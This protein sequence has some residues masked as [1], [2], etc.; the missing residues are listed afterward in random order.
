MSK[1][2]FQLIK[3]LSSAEKRYFKVQSNSGNNEKNYFRLYVAIDKMEVYSDQ[4]LLE[5]FKHEAFIDNLPF[6]KNY[7]YQ[8]ILS[9]LRQ[10]YEKNSADIQLHNQLIDVLVLE[11]KGLYLQAIK[12]SKQLKKKANLH[13]HRLIVLEVIRRELEFA[14]RSEKNLKVQLEELGTELLSSLQMLETELRLHCLKNT[15]FSLQ[16]TKAKHQ[17]EAKLNEI[18]S[19]PLLH[20]KM[21]HLSFKGQLLLNWTNAACYHLKGDFE[22]AY[23]YYKQV[24]LLWQE[25]PKIRKDKPHLYKIHL[26]NFL[27]ICHDSSN[28]TEFLDYLNKIKPLASQSFDEEAETFQNV[29]YYE[30]LYYLNTLQIKEALMLIPVIEK[31]FKKYHRK[32]NKARLIAFWYNISLLYFISENFKKALEWLTNIL[33]EPKTEHRQDVQRFARFLELVLHYELGNFQ[34]YDYLFRSLKR[35]VQKDINQNTFEATLLKHFNKLT[36]LNSGKK[37]EKLFNTFQTDLKDLSKD[38]AHSIGLEE[39]SLWV[40]SKVTGSSILQTMQPDK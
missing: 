33:H 35:Y 38:Q 29:F 40:S 31:G 17:I 24:V 19:H 20:S 23:H 30:L 18:L 10:F 6:N 7:L 2:L 3:S 37:E 28:Y 25:H 11:R 26:S 39:I 27:A 5:R 12:L 32:I 36:D 34:V 22:Q 15:V 16:R 4:L 21:E 1:D 13:D 8:A 14:L 9:S